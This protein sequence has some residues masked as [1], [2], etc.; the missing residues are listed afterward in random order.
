MRLYREGDLHE[1]GRAAHARRMTLIP[2]T[3]LRT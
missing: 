2:A 3:S 1:L